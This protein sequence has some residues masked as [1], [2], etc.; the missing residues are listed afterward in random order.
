[1]GLVLYNSY[2]N[3][4]IQLY[5]ISDNLCNSYSPKPKLFQFN[6]KLCISIMSHLLLKYFKWKQYYNMW[7]V[8][9]DIALY[10][11]CGAVTLL[12]K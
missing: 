12:W 10:M 2:R 6:T 4:I 1:M 8:S 5:Q 7:I 3:S 9:V 11:A